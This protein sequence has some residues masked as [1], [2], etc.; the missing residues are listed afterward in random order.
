LIDFFS[1]E[2]TREVLPSLVLSVERDELGIAAGL[3]DRVA[4]VYEGM[5]YMDFSQEVMCQIN[6]FWCGKYEPLS[7]A[8]VPPLYVA[9]SSDAGEPTERFHN[10]LKCEI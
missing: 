1:V 10:K 4:Q 5:V 2:I 3:Q 7:L 9:Y 8:L 6:G